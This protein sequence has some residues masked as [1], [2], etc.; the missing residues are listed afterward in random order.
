MRDPVRQW[1]APPGVLAEVIRLTSAAE[2]DLPAIASAIAQDAS[3]T[4]QLLSCVSSGYYSTRVPIT[5]VRQAV[6]FLGGSALRSLVMCLVLPRLVAADEIGGFRLDAHWEASLRRAV[7]GRCIAERMGLPSPEQ[8]FTVGLVQDVGIVLQ[9]ASDPSQGD[10]FNG[11]AG[12]PAQD[13]L[14]E[15]RMT[16]ISHDEVGAQLMLHWQLAE[17]LVAPVRFHHD[18]ELAPGSMREACNVAC[19][20]ELIADLWT[21]HDKCEALDLAETNLERVGLRGHELEMVV[22]GVNTAVMEA[23]QSFGIR[24]VQ[25]ASFQELA[26]AAETS[27][28]YSHQA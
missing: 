16:G 9:L 19:M 28:V 22:D 17:E 5:T 25:G 11:L 21:V 15:E 24:V 26:E 3:L 4:A 1:P 2:P 8:S 23:S 10:F 12:L 14:T 6:T 27:V 13:R 7:A 20:S 18:P